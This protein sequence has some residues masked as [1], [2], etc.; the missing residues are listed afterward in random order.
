MENLP[1][2]RIRIVSPDANVCMITSRRLSTLRA[3]CF[4]DTAVSVE[5]DRINAVL[6]RAIAV[7]PRLLCLL[8]NRLSA[9]VDLRLAAGRVIDPYR[10]SVSCIR[11]F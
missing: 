11:A 1:N 6:V 7:F 5:M 10:D 9:A 3:A 4:R 2:P 8:R